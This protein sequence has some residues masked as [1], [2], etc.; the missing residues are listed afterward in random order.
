[1]RIDFLGLTL[2]LFRRMWIWGIW[3]AIECFKW[4]FKNYTSKIME[5][6]VDESDL[7]CGSWSQVVSE[8][9]KFR[10]LPRYS[11]DILLKNMAVLC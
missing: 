8:K 11:S 6:S 10:M 3:E 1:M 5:A 7:N 2:L 4:V 9:K